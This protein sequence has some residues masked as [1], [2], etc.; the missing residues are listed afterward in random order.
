[1]KGALQFFSIMLLTLLLGIVVGNAGGLAI[2]YIDEYE[3]DRTIK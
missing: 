2:M 1:M 3:V